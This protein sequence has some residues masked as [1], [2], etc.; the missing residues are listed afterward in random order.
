M[1]DIHIG[2]AMIARGHTYSNAHR[3]R[4]NE[5]FIKCLIPGKDEEELVVEADGFVDLL[6][7]ILAGANVVGC[8]PAADTGIL[9]VG[10]G[11]VLGGV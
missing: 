4:S 11:L 7:E 5:D 6:V 9:E 2:S 1:C 8:E 10:E 3:R